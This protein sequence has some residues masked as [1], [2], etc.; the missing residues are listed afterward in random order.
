MVDFS[1]AIGAVGGNDFSGTV[2]AIG[3]NVTRRQVGDAVSGFLYGLDPHAGGEGEWAG[4]FAEYVSVEEGLV[5]GIKVGEG[6]IGL[7]EASCLGAGVVT[8]GMG[9]FRSLGLEE[10]SVESA[11]KAGK[12]KGFV[13]VYGGSTATGT[14]AIQL[15]RL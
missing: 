15:A 8:A 14:M 2:V 11:G 4:A 9:L 7:A 13:L 3:A 6:G 1:P 12:D 5:M 10:P